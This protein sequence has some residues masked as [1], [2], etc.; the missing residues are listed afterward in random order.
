MTSAADRLSACETFSAKV[1]TSN[2]VVVVVAGEE[3]AI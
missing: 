1:I 2:G 3:V